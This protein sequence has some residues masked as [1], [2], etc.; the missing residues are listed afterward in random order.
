MGRLLAFLLAARQ[1][2]EPLQT[3]HEHNNNRLQPL[4]AHNNN[5][6][7]GLRKQQQRTQ[8]LSSTTNRSVFALASAALALADEEVV[9]GE[10]DALARAT[11]NIDGDDSLRQR[12]AAASP[13]ATAHNFGKAVGMW[14]HVVPP[15]HP[16]SRT[17]S[18]MTRPDHRPLRSSGHSC[19]SWRQSAQMWCHASCDEGGS[20]SNPPI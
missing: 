1:P 4:H 16:A 15:R 10:I 7:R 6:L 5:R 12:L 18:R 2:L 13:L 19:H 20:R 8:R 14:A 9:G 3:I 17:W 11:A